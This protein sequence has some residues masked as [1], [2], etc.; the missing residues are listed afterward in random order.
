MVKREKIVLVIAVLGI[1]GIVLGFGGFG[2]RWRTEKEDINIESQIDSLSYSFG[3]EYAFGLKNQGFDTIIDVNL[4]CEAFRNIF[5]NDSLYISKEDGGKILDEYFFKLQQ[6]IIDKQLSEN[7][8]LIKE[9]N[10][11]EIILSSGLK[12]MIIEDK[13]GLSPH[14][15]ETVSLELLITDIDGNVLQEFPEPQTFVLSE[16]PVPILVEAIQLMSLGDKWN[17]TIP[18]E[19]A[20]GSGETVVFKVELL[21]IN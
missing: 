19:L 1:V 3:L 12:I 15:S 14:L 6:E 8:K 17:L 16:F 20:N 11:G 21:G 2:E 10:G 7:R 18:P 4:F 5:Q 9:S 13:D